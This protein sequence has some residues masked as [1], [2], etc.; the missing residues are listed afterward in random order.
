MELLT[1]IEHRRAILHITKAADMIHMPHFNVFDFTLRN[2][3]LANS[4]DGTIRNLDIVRRR[5]RYGM[6]KSPS[7]T[8]K[9]WYR[10]LARA[11]MRIAKFAENRRG[12]K[13]W[14]RAT[15]EA[16]IATAA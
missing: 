1:V 6:E 3:K 11:K 16:L 5:A 7:V 15:G 9:E 4:R 14:R 10:D 12:G 13:C 8:T 2:S